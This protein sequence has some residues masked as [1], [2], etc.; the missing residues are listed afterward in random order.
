[1]K[2][3]TRL[4]G[5]G[6]ALAVLPLVFSTGASPAEA[7]T[8][9][10]VLTRYN[11]GKDH[12]VTSGR[13][14]AGYKRE[15]SWRLAPAGAKGAQP[16]YGCVYTAAH[17]PDH[18]LSLRKDCEGKKRLR[19]EGYIYKTYSKSHPLSLYRCNWTRNEDHYASVMSNCENPPKPVKN[20]GRLGYVSA[21]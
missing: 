1:M 5:A 20:E 10:N 8:A 12:W 4:L 9:G 14:T 7:A 16:L 6:V 13:V 17:G 18:F 2:K 19:V 11:N 21:K 3:T 15:G